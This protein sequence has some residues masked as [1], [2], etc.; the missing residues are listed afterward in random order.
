[1]RQP[2]PTL[3]ALT[4]A[5]VV[6]P[7]MAPVVAL[8]A[9]ACCAPSARAA[10]V[11][12]AVRPYAEGAHQSYAL[13]DTMRFRV[14][15]QYHGVRANGEEFTI[16]RVTLVLE[17]EPNRFWPMVARLTDEEAQQLH[18]QLDALLERRVRDRAIRPG[19][20]ARV[21]AAGHG[22]NEHGLLEL[23]GDLAVRVQAEYRGIDADGEPVRDSRI[24]IIVDD[25]DRRFWPLIA[26]LHDDEARA[27]RDDLAAAIASRAER[28]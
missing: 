12:L 6:A 25:A 13:P 24:A 18:D 20:E 2:R 7:V 11:T 26:H 9:A 15:P 27:L 3:A 19:V 17:D 23:P 21:Y 14:L 16:D 10:D 1:M 8:S 28:D 4:L 22:L 5:P